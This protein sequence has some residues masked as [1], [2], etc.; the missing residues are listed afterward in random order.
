VRFSVAHELAHL[1]LIKAAGGPKKN[2][3]LQRHTEALETACNEMA[4]AILIPKYRL[5]REVQGRPHDVEHVLGL[6]KAFRVSPEVFVRRMDLRDVQGTFP[7]ADGLLGVARDIGGE[8]RIV[9]AHLW[10]A[11][12]QGR[13]SRLWASGGTPLVRD[14][15]LG[16]WVVSALRGEDR[17]RTNAEVLWRPPDHTFECEVAG[18]RLYSGPL[19]VMVG[20]QTIRHPDVMTQK[21]GGSQKTS[22]A[23]ATEDAQVGTPR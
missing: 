18:R 1:V 21:A 4:R 12:A 9:A 8:F 15:A 23:E 17:V 19:T 2:H 22:V 14:L 3:F 20:V 7:D 16:E 10:G 11:V 5:V 6:I 13:W